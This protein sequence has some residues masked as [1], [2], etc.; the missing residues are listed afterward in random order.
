MLETLELSFL[1]SLQSI[2][3]DERFTMSKLQIVEMSGCPLLKTLG[4]KELPTLKELEI[5]DCDGLESIVCGYPML[6]TLSLSYLESLESIAW[7]ERFPMLKLQ[8][9]WIWDCPMLKT[10]WMDKLPNLKHLSISECRE[11]KELFMGNDGSQMLE[12]LHFRELNNLASISPP[13]TMW[14]ER[15]MPKLQRLALRGC[16]LLSG[17]SDEKLLALTVT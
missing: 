7:D 3:W 9:V 17:L 5:S 1:K 11:L 14:N 13:C 8:S 16:P 15:T 12:T 4:M 2:V 6:E 10:L